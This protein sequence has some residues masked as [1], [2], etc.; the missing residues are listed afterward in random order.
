MKLTFELTFDQHRKWTFAALYNL[1]IRSLS[2][3]TKNILDIL[4][5]N[6]YIVDIVIQIR[7]DG[8]FRFR[9]KSQIA[10]VHITYFIYHSREDSVQV[11]RSFLL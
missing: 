6:K 2:K 7:L 3:H 10:I 4:I 11:S 1:F 8:Q 9:Q 5:H